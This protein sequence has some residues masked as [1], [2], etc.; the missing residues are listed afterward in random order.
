MSREEK[1]KFSAK[2]EK[3]V[4]GEKNLAENFRFRRQ[5]AFAPWGESGQGAFRKSLVVICGCGALGSMVANLLARAG[6]GTLRLIDFDFVQLDNLHRQ[7]LFDE[8]DAQHKTLKVQAATEKLLAANA[9]VHIEPITDRFTPENAQKLASGADLLIDGTDNFRARFHLNRTAVANGIPL[10][11]AGVLGASGQIFTVVPGETPCLEC[12]LLFDQD[13]E[14]DDSGMEA[15]GILGPTVA[16][17]ASLQA[18]EAM[19]IL[20]GQWEPIRDCA[21]F[22]FDLWKNRWTQLPVQSLKSDSPCPICRFHGE[23]R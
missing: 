21:L 16:F 19:K 11:S 2:P 9:N 13:R 3:L 22:V 18:M 4:A 1:T 6:V 23:D 7:F 15:H 8:T 12:V 17:A 14:L 5:L 20:T 10:I